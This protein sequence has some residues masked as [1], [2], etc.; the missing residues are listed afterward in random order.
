MATR[1]SVLRSL[2]EN[3]DALLRELQD[4]PEEKMTETFLGTWS[5]RE[6]LVHIGSWYDTMADALTRMGRGERPG[7]EGVDLSDSDGMNAKFV[8]AAAG[9]SVA[10][11]R[12]D[13]EAGLAT[14]EAAA[15]ALPEDRFVEG[16]TAMRILEGMAGH[17]TEHIDEVRAW[18]RGQERRPDNLPD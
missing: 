1:E 7:A 13:L 16:K 5:A 2:R 4:V 17:P 18:K 6:I 8:A 15:V 12:K 10:A 14:F 9:K 3:H 11:V